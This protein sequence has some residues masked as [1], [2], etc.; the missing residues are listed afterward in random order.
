MTELKHWN[1]QNLDLKTKVEL[2]KQISE[3]RK[4]YNRANV[5]HRNIMKKP[6]EELEEYYK[7]RFRVGA[8][9]TSL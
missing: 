1:K 5:H 2:R 8:L 7:W 4:D 9:Y 3:L 6:L